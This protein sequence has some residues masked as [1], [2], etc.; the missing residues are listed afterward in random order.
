MSIYPLEIYPIIFYAPLL[1]IWNIVVRFIDVL[2]IKNEMIRILYM[3]LISYRRYGVLEYAI[4]VLYVFCYWKESKA[5]LIE[6]K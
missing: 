1:V 3:T 4:F 6:H 2:R 5:N